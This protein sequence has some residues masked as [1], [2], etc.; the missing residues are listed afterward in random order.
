MMRTAILSTLILLLI[1]TDLK[2]QKCAPTPK[3]AALAS[4]GDSQAAS[5]AQAVERS[6]GGYRALD[7]YVDPVLRRAWIRVVHCADVAISPILVPIA[8]PLRSASGAVQPRGQNAVSSISSTD[9]STKPPQDVSLNTPRPLS[10]TLVH[11]GDAVRVVYISALVR[12]ELEAV[13]RQPGRAGDVIDL[14]LKRKPGEALNE[15]EHRIHGMVHADGT[16][17]VTP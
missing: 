13:A 5:N 2:A 14:T 16:I 4:L 11:V 6:S 9:L 12:M 3:G 7:L 15:P 1:A 8:V 17:E 10:P